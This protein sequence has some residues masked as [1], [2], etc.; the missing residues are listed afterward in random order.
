[1]KSSAAHRVMLWLAWC[2]MGCLSSF[3]MADVVRLETTRDTWVSAFPGEEDANLGGSGRLKLKG[4]QEMSI[5]DF[6]TT[7]LRGRVV[8]GVTLHLFPLVN[9]RPRRVTV[10]TLATPWVEGT[11]GGYSKQPGA[12][13][14]R[15]AKQGVL[16]WAGRGSDLTGAVNGEGGTIW[17]FGDASE[18][19]AK[20]YQT[21]PVDPRVV[22]ARAAGLSEGFVLF[23]DVGTEWSRQGD[24]LVWNV[25]LNRFIASREAGAARAPYLMVKLG[26]ADREPPQAPGNL[27]WQNEGLPPGEAVVTWRTPRDQGPAGV[28]GFEVRYSDK[29]SFNWMMATPVPRYMIPAAAAEGEPVTM[30]LRDLPKVAAG[31]TLTVGVR[32]VDAAGNASDMTTQ[33]GVISPEVSFRL[34]APPVEPFVELAL[35]PTVG[36]LEVFVVDAL[37]KVNPLTGQF[38][39]TRPESYTMANHIWSASQRVVRLHAAR[40]EAVDFQVLLRGRSP[41]VNVTFTFDDPGVA[42]TALYLQRNVKTPAGMLPDP[43]EP[44]LGKVAVPDAGRRLPGQR[45]AA[46]YAEAQVSHLTPPGLHRGTLKVTAPNG[47]N[48][49]LAVELNVWPFALPDELSFIPQMNCYGLPSSTEDPLGFAYYRMAHRH[50][51]SLNRLNYNWRGEPN[52]AFIPKVRGDAWDWSGFDRNFAPLFDGS[53]FKGLPRDGVP[54]EVFYL[55]LNENWPVPIEEGYRGGYW[56]ETALTDAYRAKF[57]DGARRFARHLSDKKWT[58]T[59]F[60]F[61][62]NNKVYNR[63]DGWGRTSAYWVLDEPVNTQ[64]FWALRW[65]GVAFHEGVAAARAETPGETARLVF[66]ADIS[67]PQWQ[68]NMLDGVLD[69]NVVGGPFRPYNRMILD[70]KRRNG[71]VVYNYAGS[72]PID[73]S[74]VTPAAWC[75]DTWTLGGDGVLPWQTIGNEKSWQDGDE[76]SLFYPGAAVGLPGPVASLRLKS[77]RRGQQDVEYLSLLAGVPAS[78]RWAVAA[79]TRAALR[80]EA[81]F[82]GGAEDDAGRLEFDAVDPVALWR[83]RLSVGQA[84]ADKGIGAPPQGFP[85]TPPRDQAKA[86]NLRVVQTRAE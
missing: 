78:P 35:P 8:T 81:R 39:P 63:R 72:N 57:V 80:L 69:V 84:L 55:P 51:T 9:E 46:V 75:I 68:R 33:R 85:V 21:I 13:S 64:D 54:V 16:P 66:R 15:W 58:R 31:A 28:L 4:I 73:R 11:S 2:C 6:D 48:V 76:E 14:F 56:A 17:S 60:E 10:S 18:P 22:A 1:M 29:S 47:E 42:E 37:D 59:M 50:R 43:L 41:G 74:N 3:V 25:F 53:A 49:T 27:S 65:Y 24:R 44:L 79:A 26:P 34:G 40:G 83:L 70:R 32:A 23:D 82:I 61:Y 36:D 52:E 62:L 38:I 20:G 71:E 12:A 7:P 5:V 19:D 86:P 77:Y 45:L 67:R 30:H